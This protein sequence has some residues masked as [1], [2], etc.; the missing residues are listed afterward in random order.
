MFYPISKTEPNLVFLLAIY[1]AG[2]VFYH[3]KRPLFGK[4]FVSR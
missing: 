4:D 3:L 1:Y 2:R